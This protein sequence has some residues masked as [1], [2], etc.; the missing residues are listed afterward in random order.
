MPWGEKGTVFRARAD[1]HREVHHQ[2]HYLRRAS[3]GVVRCQRA[4]AHQTGEHLREKL[5]PGE[6]KL[7]LTLT[8]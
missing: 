4:K 1:E 8:V 2:A 5:Q 6:K 3:E 7:I